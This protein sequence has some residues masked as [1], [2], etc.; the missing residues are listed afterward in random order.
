MIGGIQSDSLRKSANG[1][2]DVPLSTYDYLLVALDCYF[3]SNRWPVKPQRVIATSLQAKGSP[4]SKLLPVL[5]GIWIIALAGAANAGGA[6]ALTDTQMDRVTAGAASGSFDFSK[7]LS[8]TTDNNVNFTGN[9]QIIDL[10]AKKAFIAVESK[11][12]GNSA[13]LAFDNEAVGKNSNVQGSFSQISVA[14]QGS[15]QSGLFV[16]AANGAMKRY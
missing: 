12:K 11:V 2:L 4:M 10:F 5:T 14:G 9:S 13:S 16:S 1:R 7:N 8:S 15:S 3:L 6:V